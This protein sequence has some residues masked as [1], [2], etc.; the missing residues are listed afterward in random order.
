MTTPAQR[1][2]LTEGQT[3]TVTSDRSDWRGNWVFD[4]DD[5]TTFP[6]FR[7]MEN[8]EVRAC[9]YV[10]GEHN[11]VFKPF[12]EGSDDFNIDVKFKKD[13]VVNIA[14]TKKLTSDQVAAILKIVGL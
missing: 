13:G 3:Y 9:I 10:N 5:N 4:K 14:I 2:G 6:Y 11:T 12:G 1:A 7:L 8:S